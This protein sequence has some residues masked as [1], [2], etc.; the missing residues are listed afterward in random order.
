[1]C[2][3][4]GVPVTRVDKLILLAVLGLALGSFAVAGLRRG[5]EVS[6]AQAQVVVEVDGR[7]VD[8]FPLADL[9]PGERR[10]VRG[11]LGYSVI[12]GGDNKVR[13]ESSPCPDKVCVARGWISLPGEAIVCMPNHI[14]VHIVGPASEKSYDAVTQ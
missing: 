10:Q 11:P 4:R 8:K 9:K 5:A 3:K 12:I 2:A 7:V 14:V 6:P 1:M 13:M